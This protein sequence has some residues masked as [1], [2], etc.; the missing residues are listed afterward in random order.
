MRGE[1]KKKRKQVYLT[2]LHHPKPYIIQAIVTPVT[3]SISWIVF[4]DTDRRLYA[5]F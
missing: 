3:V 4:P 2:S 1:K 5:G